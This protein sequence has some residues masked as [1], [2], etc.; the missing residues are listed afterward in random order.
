MLCAIIFNTFNNFS[1]EYCETNVPA[2][3]SSVFVFKSS[4]EARPNQKLFDVLFLLSIGTE[5]VAI[6]EVILFSS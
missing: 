4:N 2:A 5:E 3:D 1:P 6:D